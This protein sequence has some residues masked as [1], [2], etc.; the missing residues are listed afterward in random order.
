[1]WINEEVGKQQLQ[2]ES[3]N[4]LQE[5]SERIEIMSNLSKNLIIFDPYPTYEIPIAKSYLNKIENGETQYK[6]SILT[7]CLILHQQK[8]F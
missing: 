8:T 2:C 7:G 5:I 4:Y 1:M 3:C 6:F